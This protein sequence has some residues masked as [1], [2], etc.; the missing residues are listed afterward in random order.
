MEWKNIKKVK[1]NPAV[2]SHSASH[3]ERPKV[4]RYAWNSPCVQLGLVDLNCKSINVDSKLI[5]NDVQQ[6]SET[7][8][9]EKEKSCSTETSINVTKISGGTEIDTVVVLGKN[10]DSIVVVG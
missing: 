3:E 9:E 4:M 5:N 6:Q 8:S 7:I 10:G 2:T 1:R